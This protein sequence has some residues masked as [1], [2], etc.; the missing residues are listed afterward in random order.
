MFGTLVSRTIGCY[1]STNRRTFAAGDKTTDLGTLSLVCASF[2]DTTRSAIPFPEFVSRGCLLVNVTSFHPFARLALWCSYMDKF[3]RGATGLP[4]ESV[5]A[6]IINMMEFAK[7]IFESLM[8]TFKVVDNPM[9]FPLMEPV[10]V[11]ERVGLSQ[12]PVLVT[13]CD[14]SKHH[15]VVP[16]NAWVAGPAGWCVWR[17]E[18]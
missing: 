8:R 14:L 4:R 12:T 18:A 17:A 16:P 6:V 9:R 1:L 7:P 15:D 5:P 10:Q 3:D 2:A 11:Q 13:M